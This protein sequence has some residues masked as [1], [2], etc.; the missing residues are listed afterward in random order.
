MCHG[1]CPAVDKT[2]LV[3]EELVMELFKVIDHGNMFKLGVSTLDA[4]T[5]SSQASRSRFV[6]VSARTE[7]L[8]PS[9][10]RGFQP[11]GGDLRRDAAKR[12][13]WSFK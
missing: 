7:I 6:L 3:D 12:A 2:G 4:V 10:I 13:S 5:D 9:R 8:I 1:S 11:G